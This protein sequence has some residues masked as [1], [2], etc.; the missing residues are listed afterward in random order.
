MAIFFNIFGKT[1][2]R[3]RRDKKRYGQQ[4]CGD[5][6]RGPFTLH[7]QASISLHHGGH[8]PLQ[9]LS[10]PIFNIRGKHCQYTISFGGGMRGRQRRHH[11]ALLTLEEIV[12]QLNLKVLCGTVSYDF[13]RRPQNNPAGETAARQRRDTARQRRDSGE[14]KSDILYCR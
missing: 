7:S 8:Q 13:T 12:H 4:N 6:Q 14:T 11:R 10:S 2:A 1:A 5:I 3:Q 9:R